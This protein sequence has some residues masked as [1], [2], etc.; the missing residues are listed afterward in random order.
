MNDFMFTHE[1]DIRSRIK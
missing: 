1:R